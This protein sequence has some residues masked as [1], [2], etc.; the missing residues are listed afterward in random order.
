MNYL[1]YNIWDTLVQT[2]NIRPIRLSHLVVDQNGTDIVVTFTLLDAPPR[3][4]PVETPLIETSFDKLIETL[5]DVINRNALIF[6]PRTG[7]KLIT[8][9][10]RAESL[11]I[12]HQSSTKADRSSG[13]LITGLWIGCVVAGLLIGGVASFCTFEKLAKRSR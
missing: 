9:R 11:N 13:P 3:T 6:R 4:G 7:T 8:L 5:T 12:V 2:L 1:R 10:A